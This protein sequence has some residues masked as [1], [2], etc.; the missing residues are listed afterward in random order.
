MQATPTGRTALVPRDPAGRA[1]LARFFR[2]PGDPGRL[3]LLAF[4]ADA[5]RAGTACVQHTGLARSRVP[6]HLACLVTCGLAE[7]RRDG[8]LTRY[9][10]HGQR[11]LELVRLAAAMAAGDAAVDACTQVNP[12]S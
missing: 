5:G 6:A 3:A 9:A 12:P 11:P 10:V 2:A 8:R 7:A 4:A 1:V